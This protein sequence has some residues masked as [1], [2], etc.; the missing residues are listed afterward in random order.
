MFIIYII[1]III[2]LVSL[3]LPIRYKDDPKTGKR[4]KGREE[5]RHCGRRLMQKITYK[6]GDSPHES[7]HARSLRRATQSNKLKN[8]TN[9]CPDASN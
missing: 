4:K 3:K 8:K 9:Y 5:K 2:I 1:T 7:E 6:F